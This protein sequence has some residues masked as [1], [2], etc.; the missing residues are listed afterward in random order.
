MYEINTLNYQFHNLSV[1]KL[2][3]QK[4]EAVKIFI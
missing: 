4:L 3:I 1:R 2:S